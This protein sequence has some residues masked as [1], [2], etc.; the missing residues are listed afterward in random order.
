MCAHLATT[1]NIV[2]SLGKQWK[3]YIQ[4]YT[5]IEVHVFPVKMGNTNVCYNY[6]KRVNCE[7]CM[8]MQWSCVMTSIRTYIVRTYFLLIAKAVGMSLYWHG[9]LDSRWWVRW[10]L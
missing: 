10:R 9:S 7:V 2:K 1:D 6:S 8:H 3:A 4:L 5:N